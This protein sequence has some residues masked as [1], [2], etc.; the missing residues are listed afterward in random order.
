VALHGNLRRWVQQV[1]ES[2]L[3]CGRRPIR[4]SPLSCAETSNLRNFAGPL[5][6]E[7]R[8]AFTYG[9]FRALRGAD[10]TRRAP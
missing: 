7:G 5:S 10:R 9:R 2:F 3:E 6:P 4:G 8:P 1:I